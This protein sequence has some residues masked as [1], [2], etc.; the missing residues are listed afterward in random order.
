ME[1]PEARR[2]ADAVVATHEAEVETPLAI[3]EDAIRRI[4]QGW[5]FYWNTREAVTT[6]DIAKGLV[7]QGPLLVLDNGRVLEGGSAERPDDVLYRHGLTGRPVFNAEVEWA[8]WKGSRHSA[9]GAEYRAKARIEGD[10]AA[11]PLPVLMTRGPS[12]STWLI[13]FESI[14][15]PHEV[16]HSGLNLVLFEGSREAGRAVLG[17]KERLPG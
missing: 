3:R 6:R 5:V 14:N 4:D 15:G 13:R 9:G 16:L 11:P 12:P 1:L 7:G 8:P 10:E 2:L 17:R